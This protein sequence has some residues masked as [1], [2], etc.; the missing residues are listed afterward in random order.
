M[1]ML[2]TQDGK[3]VY[4]MD[5]I[6]QIYVDK[7][8]IVATDA[9]NAFT[10][11]KYRSSNEAERA[12]DD[13]IDAIAGEYEGIVEV[14]RPYNWYVLAIKWDEPIRYAGQTKK[15]TV[16]TIMAHDTEDAECA[17]PGAAYNYDIVK[18]VECDSKDKAETVKAEW[19][20]VFA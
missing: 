7:T 8:C 20:K 19:E 13:V 12:F 17:I 4:N 11:G 5:F 9:Y 15:Y 6:K 2:L 1:T 18:V 14:P 3:N 10:V 16:Y